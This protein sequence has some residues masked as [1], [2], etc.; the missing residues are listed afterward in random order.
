MIS[1]IKENKSK[2]LQRL[3]REVAN[4]RKTEPTNWRGHKLHSS[5]K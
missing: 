3:M 2:I 5:L 4:Q 1:K